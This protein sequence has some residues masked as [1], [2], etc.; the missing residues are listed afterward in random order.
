MEHR[1]TSVFL[2]RLLPR[3]LKVRSQRSSPL[4]AGYPNARA[5]RTGMRPRPGPQATRRR[6]Q[7]TP[8][9]PAC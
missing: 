7:M 4:K 3:K 1:I 6:G 2:V 5:A 9:L 8:T